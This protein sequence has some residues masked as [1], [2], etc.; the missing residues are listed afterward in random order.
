MQK[1][2]TKPELSILI[3]LALLSIGGAVSK[4]LV[5]FDIDEGYAI[6]MPQR[7]L[8]GD[9]MLLD[10]WEVHQ[11]SSFLPAFFLWAFKKITGGVE[12]AALY[13]RIVASVL[14]LLMTAVVWK[15]LKQVELKWRFLFCLL[16]FNFLPK[17]MLSL[18]FSMQ[19]LWSV[20][21]VM[22]LLYREAQTRKMRWAFAAGLALAC[23]VLAYP[24]MALLYPFVLICVCRGEKGKT[25]LYKCGAVTMGCALLAVLFFAY[26][27]SYMSV[28]DLIESVP[29]VFM[30]GTHQFTMGVKLM[31]YAGQWCNA[32]RQIL[33]LAA[34]TAVLTAVIMAIWRAKAGRQK[35]MDRTGGAMAV[36]VLFLLVWM[37]VTSALVVFANAVG[38]SMGPFHFQVRYLFFFAASFV[39]CL[40]RKR[41]QEDLFY[42]VFVLNLVSFISILLFSN[43]GPDASSSY[44][45]SGVMGGFMLLHKCFSGRPAVETQKGSGRLRFDADHIAWL[46]CAFFVVSLIFCKGYYVRVTEY[47][48]STICETREQVTRGALEGLFL[49]PADRERYETAH[50]AIAHA[51]EDGETLLFLGTEGILNLSARGAFVSPS[52]IS[53]PAFNEQWTLYFTMYPKKIPDVIVI[54]KNTVDN[55]EKF[56]ARNPFGCWIAENYDILHSEETQDLCIVRKR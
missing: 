24:A 42:I 51:T 55:R 53:T 29:L 38:V 52:T 2:L 4:V 41:E 31:A 6:S 9:R 13:L 43:V 50:E 48:P 40:I 34:P 18:D 11:T 21:L 23:A 19:Q 12:C 30:D 28:S 56:F 20:T 10:M 5:G 35:T 39:L 32:G 3:V 17:W 36:Y 25:G 54:A 44:L 16:Y 7:L 47:A 15:G 22:Y 1:K 46:V 26:L 37:A 27:F 14:H 33:I 49:L 45:V 8:G